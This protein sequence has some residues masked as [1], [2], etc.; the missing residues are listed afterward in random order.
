MQDL[1]FRFPPMRSVAAEIRTP[2]SFSEVGFSLL[3]KE[4]PRTA[5]AGRGAVY[6]GGFLPYPKVP[7]GLE[8][9]A[10]GFGFGSLSYAARLVGNWCWRFGL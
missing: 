7:M 4:K 9:G 2:R 10:V 8:L 1:F 6:G 5:Y 3:T